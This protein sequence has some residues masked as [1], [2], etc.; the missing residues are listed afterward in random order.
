MEDK[1]VDSSSQSDV[2]ELILDYLVFT[3]T[4]TILKDYQNQSGKVDNTQSSNVRMILRMLDSQY[5]GPALL[6]S[7]SRLTL[8][9]A[10]MIIYR[11]NQ[12]NNKCDPNLRFRLRLLKFAVLFMSRSGSRET[13]PSSL[14]LQKCRQKRRRQ[15]SSF[16]SS[17]DDVTRLDL[18][19]LTEY[20]PPSDV[21]T[22][23]QERVSPKADSVSINAHNARQQ[24]YPTQIPLLDTLP[25]FMSLSA[26]QNAMQEATITD[27]WMHLAAGFMVQAVAEQYLTYESHDPSVLEEAFAWGFDAN[28][29]A[30]EGTDEWQINAMFY[31]EDGVVS[32]WESIRDEHM[33]AVG[34]LFLHMCLFA[35]IEIFL[36]DSARRY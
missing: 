7:T 11:A 12:P 20:L 15:A 36:D 14:A 25:A 10:Y 35:N 34:Q 2:E 16:R 19:D 6:Y 13:V 29:D 31:G 28:C 24:P 18:P 22:V 4:T 5:S 33:H 32:G 26:A 9:L 30:E 23:K 8:P 3:A 27:V 21:V 17:S 1:R